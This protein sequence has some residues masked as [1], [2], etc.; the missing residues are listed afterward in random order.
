MFQKLDGSSCSWSSTCPGEHQKTVGGETQK[1]D[2]QTDDTM[3]E[4]SVLHDVAEYNIRSW[5]TSRLVF[6]G[7]RVHETLAIVVEGPLVPLEVNHEHAQGL[8]TRIKLKN[9]HNAAAFPASLG[10]PAEHQRSPEH[11][12]PSGPKGGHKMRAPI[13]FRHGTPALVSTG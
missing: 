2:R 7:Q 5:F 13:E 11:K 9:Q 8:D 12:R 3:F 10:C 1:T 6:D 4:V